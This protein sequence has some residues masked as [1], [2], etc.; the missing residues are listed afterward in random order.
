MVIGVIGAGIA[1]LIAGRELAKHGHEVIVLEKSR[2]L[3]GRLA[4]RYAGPD[5]A[6][7][8]DHGSS[9][10]SATT[11][12]FKT[13]LAELESKGLVAPWTDTFAYYTK[14]AFYS[15]HPS[16]EPEMVYIAPAGMNAIGKY[17]SRWVD[18]RLDTKVGGLT[19]VAPGH[20]SKRPWIINMADTSVLE[21][22]A[23]ILATPSI[24]A[25]GLLS[26]AQDETP[27]R[28]LHMEVSKIQYTPS[29]SVMAGYGDC[30]LSEWKGLLCQDDVIAWISNESTKRDNNELTLVAHATAEFS[31]AHKNESKEAV[32]KIILKR[33]AKILGSWAETP[34][35]SQTHFWRYHR[36]SNSVN[37]PFLENVNGATPMALTGDYFN[38]NS[39]EAAYVSGLA[40]ARHWIAK[41]PK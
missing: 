12:E 16:R 32:E 11:S 10:L 37:A 36:P 8:L 22:D 39:I 15:Q 21:V 34:Y 6:V 28:S 25:A 40:L 17:L 27:V 33:L 24:Q 2:G 9:Y 31:E 7:K 13:F 3:G 29:F 5:N 20:H 26:T 38:G 18:I 1:G 41:Y 4:T 14:D 35:W 19:M 23:V 30:E